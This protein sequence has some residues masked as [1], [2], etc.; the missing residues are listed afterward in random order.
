MLLRPLLALIA[1]ITQIGMTPENVLYWHVQMYL[2]QATNLNWK[3]PILM[4]HLQDD[5]VG[6]RAAASKL[7]VICTRGGSGCIR[8]ATHVF[9]LHIAR[10]FVN[11]GHPL[12]NGT[13]LQGLRRSRQRRRNRA[14]EIGLK[15]SAAFGVPSGGETIY[16][17]R[18]LHFLSGEH[19]VAKRKNFASTANDVGGK[20]R[21][22]PPLS[23][24]WDIRRTAEAPKLVHPATFPGC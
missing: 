3:Q 4:I 19:S 18:N 2:E 16:P 8:K 23:V 5:A 17:P 11:D 10:N 7:F 13:V 9:Q 14:Q 15:R 22:K 1:T 12:R 20:E 6:F 21:T 24:W